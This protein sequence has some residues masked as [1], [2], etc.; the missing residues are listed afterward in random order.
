VKLFFNRRC[1]FNKKARQRE[2]T[3]IDALQIPTKPPNLVPQMQMLR[4]WFEENDPE[5]V[6]F[7]YEVFDR[8]WKPPG[9]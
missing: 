8:K 3:A 7:E 4:T 6:A 5:G 2:P 9:V 1:H